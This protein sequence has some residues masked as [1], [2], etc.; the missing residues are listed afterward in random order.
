MPHHRVRELFAESSLFWHA[1]GFGEDTETRPE[2]AEHFGIAPVEAMAAGS[3]PLVVNK[4]GPAEIVEHEVTG[5]HWKTL[6]EL[7]QWTWRLSQDDV[8][9]SALADAARTAARAYSTDQ[10]LARMSDLSGVPWQ[11][12]TPPVFISV[13][14][15]ERVTP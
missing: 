15:A 10:F 11:P 8:L 9:R 3:V 14:N 12:S 6:A 2:L 5:I 1:T 4:G 7:S 13:G